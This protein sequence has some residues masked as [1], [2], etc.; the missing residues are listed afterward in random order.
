M[1]RG[2][3]QDP[4]Q[5][6]MHKV[7]IW[8]YSLT[9]P[10]VGASRVQQGDVVNEA[11]IPS[12]MQN[13]PRPGESAKRDLFFVVPMANCLKAEAA[14]Q[15]ADVL[16][17]SNQC[18]MDP[19]PCHNLLDDSPR[20]HP[21]VILSRVNVDKLDEVDALGHAHPPR[22][23]LNDLRTTSPRFDLNDLRTVNPAVLTKSRFDLNGLRT[24]NPAALTKSRFDLNDLR[25]I[26]PSLIS[27]I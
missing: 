11:R 14:Q 10:V 21:S 17:G 25:T 12:S 20:G 22:F 15:D 18:H 16:F 8:P 7:Y 9:I 23:D 13:P 19:L 2:L 26:K 1:Q 6:W 27:N 5:V 4:Q 3:L 24:V